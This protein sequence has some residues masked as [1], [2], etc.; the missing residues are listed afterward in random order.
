MRAGEQLQLTP[1]TA[2]SGVSNFTFKLSSIQAQRFASRASATAARQGTSAAG[3]QLIAQSTSAGL[4]SFFYD[5]NIGALVYEPPAA[6]ST[7][8]TGTSGSTG[9][10]GATGQSNGVVA[11]GDAVARAFKS[12][13]R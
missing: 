8:S 2:N 10:T 13:Q 1:T 7:G 5:I 3:E 4:A 9:S 6:G 11:V 12:A